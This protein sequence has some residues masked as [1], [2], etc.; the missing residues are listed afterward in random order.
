MT[1]GLGFMCEDGIVVAADRQMTGSNY[2]FREGKVFPLKWKNGGALWAYAGNRDKAMKLKNEAE[3]QFGAETTLN[4]EAVR[5]TWEA[6]LKLS[7]KKGDKFQTLFGCVLRGTHWLWMSNGREIAEVPDCEIIGLGD[8]PLARYLRGNF[9]RI[10]GPIT[11]EQARLYA[12]H[13]VS[14]AEQYDGEF[15]SGGADIG[16]VNEKWTIIFDAAQTEEWAKQIQELEYRWELLFRVL[17][18]R[19]FD[20]D[21]E[22]HDAFVGAIVRFKNWLKDNKG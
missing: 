2:T 5:A 17:A 3:S 7:L 6:T 15:C 4:K 16:E 18:N 10:P 9:I 21:I 11:T 1:V 13:F 22:M 20:F 19:T 8:S 12:A 14:L